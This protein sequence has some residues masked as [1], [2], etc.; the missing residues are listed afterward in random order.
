MKKLLLLLF[1]GL[2]MSPVIKAQEKDIALNLKHVMS[3]YKLTEDQQGIERQ[4]TD[5]VDGMSYKSKISYDND[6]K[7][8][9]IS[10]FIGY[11]DANGAPVTFKFSFGNDA[12]TNGKYALY[13]YDA[14]LDVTKPASENP[15]AYYKWVSY[16][17]GESNFFN[18]FTL[19]LEQNPNTDELFNWGPYISGIFS[20][21]GDYEYKLYNPVVWVIN[22]DGF[23]HINRSW[24]TKNADGSYNVVV[25]LR[26]TVCFRK[27]AESDD[28]PSSSYDGN[29]DE[30]LVSDQYHEL[31]FVVNPADLASVDDVIADNENAPVEYYNLQGVKVEN[32]SNGLY[33]VR[34]GNKVSKQ[35]IK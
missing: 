19:P 35:V 7:Q 6:I 13:A 16:V 32:P 20:G 34:Q 1:M 21:S 24:A 18:R 33:I 26:C 22:N 29:D 23:N 28:W 8:Y 31:S 4:W 12:D 25:Q 5:I 10:D 9:V 11:K 15:D 17:S 14:N 27:F 30:H 2:L 3:C